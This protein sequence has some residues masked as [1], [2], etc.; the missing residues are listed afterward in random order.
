MDPSG[1]GGGSQ[2]ILKRLL[3]GNLEAPGVETQTRGGKGGLGCHSEAP[4]VGIKQGGLKGT[5]FGKQSL[6]LVLRVKN[7]GEKCA[8]LPPGEEVKH[9][10]EIGRTCGSSEAPGVEGQTRGGN[11]GG[12][13]KI[14]KDFK[15]T[16]EAPGV[17]TQPRGGKGGRGRGGHSEALGVENKH[18]GE[19]GTFFGKQSLAPGLRVKNV[20]FCPPVKRSNTGGK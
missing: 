19:I 16:S 20:P 15:G 3:K 2:K 18:G 17:G 13:Q 7:G 8:F 14:L 4:G 9:G 6:A 10:G 1:Q 5:L 11:R 12:S